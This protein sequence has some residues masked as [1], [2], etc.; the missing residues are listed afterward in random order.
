MTTYNILDYGAIADG[1]TNCA[2]AIQ[3]AVDEASHAGGGRVL[4][5]AGRFL[6]G[7]V[8]LKSNVELHLALGATLLSSLDESQI[9]P[10]PAADEDDNKETGW[11]GGFFLGARDAQN[12][13][14]T[15]LGVIDGQGDKVFLDLDEDNG[16]HECPKTCTAFRPRMMLFEKVTNFVVKDV[17]LKDAAFW[18]LHMAG[19][20][21]VR[22]SGIMILNDDRGA[23]NDGI[24]PD[25]CQDV[26]VSDCIIRTGDDAI[27]LKSTKPMAKRYGPCENVTI[28]NC[29]L[30]SRDSA[31][32]IGTET[33]GVI[34]NVILSDCV[35]QDCSRG[36]GVWVRD[37]GT[38]E[39]IHL[40]HLTGATRRYADRYAIP[41]APGWWGKGE[42]IFISATHRKG[43][44]DAFPGVIR[45][46]TVDHVNLACESCIFLGG[47]KESPIEN[48]RMSDIDLTFRKQG[49]QPGSLFDEQPS[50]RHIYPHNI[51]AL[52]AR[53]VNGLRLRDSHVTFEGEGMPWDGALTELEHCTRTRIAWENE[54]A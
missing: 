45:N 37:G 11:D 44:E 30:H 10:F 51:P 12:V 4:I 32:K 48:V 20:K 42:P 47:E 36:V 26:V 19:C 35:V 22:I 50:G 14:V 2:P 15:G 18:T 54:E 1:V 46:V 34:R 39:N 5:P 33:H 38:V 8:L 25:C 6:S 43:K 9:Q 27:V 23:N 29:V 41:G 16:F 49:T 17:T 7:T 24:D 13:A 28:T 3:R 52:Y 40:H 53:N 21:H 31:L